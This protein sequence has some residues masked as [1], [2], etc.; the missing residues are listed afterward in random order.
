[1]VVG[2]D[3]EHRVAIRMLRSAAVFSVADTAT[4]AGIRE[5]G[6]ASCSG[7]TARPRRLRSR[8]SGLEPS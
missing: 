2:V 5:S 6:V 7:S 4:A 1:M 8:R 3:A